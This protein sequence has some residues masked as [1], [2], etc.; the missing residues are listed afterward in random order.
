M[1]F[2][3]DDSNLDGVVLG[4]A[5]GIG[6]GLGLGILYAPN[7]GIKTRKALAKSANRSIGQ[8]KD[9]VDDIRSSA[10]TLMDKGK[11]AMDE[12]RETVS[13]A[14]DGVKKTYR[15]VVG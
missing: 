4:L 8:F 15:Q 10:S 5:I 6:I 12:H 11:Q 14:I 3:D 9:T 2:R 7:S 13:D 1:A